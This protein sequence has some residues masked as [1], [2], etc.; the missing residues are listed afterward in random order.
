[1]KA[2]LDWFYLQ[3]MRAFAVVGVCFALWH[4]GIFALTKVLDVE[5]P[6]ININ[7]EEARIFAR[8]DKF[9]RN[10]VPLLNDTESC[11]DALRTYRQLGKY[12]ADG[13]I[14]NEQMETADAAFERK[15]IRR[16]NWEAQADA[17][18][19]PPGNGKSPAY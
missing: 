3:N 5:D 19:I 8:V 14:N 10:P 15:G 13:P 9:C 12:K 1:M 11:E 18:E 17:A 6:M 16:K 2:F 4:G 7:S